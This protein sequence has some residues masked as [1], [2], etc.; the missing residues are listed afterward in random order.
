[1]STLSVILVRG[2]EAIFLTQLAR[3]EVVDP[4]HTR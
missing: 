1:M 3:I 2:H 4:R